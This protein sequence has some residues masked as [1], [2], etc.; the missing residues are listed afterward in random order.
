MTVKDIMEKYG[1]KQAELGRRFSIP[2]RSLQHW[3]SDPSK[4]D[5][6]ECP[7]YLIEMMDEC[8]SHSKEKPNK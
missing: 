8:L 6:R 2:V 4:P 5:Y 7:A 1:L 3:C